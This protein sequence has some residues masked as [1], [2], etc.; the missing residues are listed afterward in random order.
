MVNRDE[1]K[2]DEIDQSNG[3]LQTLTI[4]GSFDARSIRHAPQPRRYRVELG[5]LQ[6]RRLRRRNRSE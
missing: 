1:S 3:T 4:L 2:H 5:N 6:M